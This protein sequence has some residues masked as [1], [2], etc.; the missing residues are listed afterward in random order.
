VARTSGTCGAVSGAILAINLLT[1]RSAPGAPV[2]D[3]YAAVRKLVDTFQERFGS[4]NCGELLGC[5]LGT[6]EGQRTF[7]EKNLHARC[8]DYA[9]EATRIALSIIEEMS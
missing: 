4:T 3:N 6:E 2:D 1:G 9:E 7:R 5:H 8:L